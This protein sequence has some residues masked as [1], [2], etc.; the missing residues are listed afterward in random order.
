MARYPYLTWPAGFE[1]L[2]QAVEGG[3]GSMDWQRE[4]FALAGS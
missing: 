3:P 2:R 1:V 4:G